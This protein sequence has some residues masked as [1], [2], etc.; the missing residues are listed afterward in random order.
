MDNNKEV[1]IIEKKPME[2]PV[3]K[4]EK[5]IAMKNSLEIPKR[6]I[7]VMKIRTERGI[8]TINLTE[9]KIIRRK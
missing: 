5:K 8:I 1:E 6:K 4:N 3:L 7:K 2:I 9:M